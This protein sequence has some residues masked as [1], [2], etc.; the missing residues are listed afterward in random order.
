VQKIEVVVLLDMNQVYT[1]KYTGVL[2][3]YSKKKTFKEIK[4]Y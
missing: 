1:V 4:Y 2:K 3:G